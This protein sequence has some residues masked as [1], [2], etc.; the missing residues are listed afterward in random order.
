M[1]QTLQTLTAVQFLSSVI[2][3]ED[4]GVVSLD[5]GCW[6]F[7]DDWRGYLSSGEMRAFSLSLVV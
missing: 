6:Q 5:F 3:C 4:N 7:Y 1:L 2:Q